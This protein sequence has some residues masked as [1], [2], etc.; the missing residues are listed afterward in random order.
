M[1]KKNVKNLEE[2]YYQWMNKYKDDSDRRGALLKDALEAIDGMSLDK[3]ALRKEI[4][5][6]IKNA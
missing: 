4:E 1:L 3:V 5:Q 6:E 2:Y